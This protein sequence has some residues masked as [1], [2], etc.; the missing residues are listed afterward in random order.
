MTSERGERRLAAN[1]SLQSR[2][3]GFGEDLAEGESTEWRRW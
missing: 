1:E 3:E 2:I